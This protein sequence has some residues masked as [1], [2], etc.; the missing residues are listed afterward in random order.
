M[1]NSLWA[2][3]ILLA[4]LTGTTQTFMDGGQ[5][6]NVMA[7]AMF[8]SAKTGV[9]LSIGLIAAL[10]FWLGLFQIGEAAG[11]VSGLARLL[12]PILCRL[13]PDI[14]RGHPVLASIGMNIAMSMLGIDNGALPSGLK[15]MEEL[16]HLKPTNT[17]VGIASRSQQM[18]LVY[19]TCSVTLF[20]ISIMAYRMQAGATHPADVFLPLLLAGYAGLFAGLA[21]MAIVQRLR[22]LDPVLLLSATLLVT[23]LSGIAWSI[24]SLPIASIGPAV[25]LTGN[26][27]LLGT[28]ALFILLA[29]LRKVPVYNTFL[30]GAAKGF[31]MA[32]ELIPYIVG[33][34]V[35]IGLLRASGAFALLQ[36]T[37][38]WACHA[39]GIDSHWALGIPQGIMKTF[40]GAGSRAIMLDTFT[41]HGP[42]SYPGYLS[43]IIQGKSD[44]TFYILAA[45]AGAARLKHLGH[46]VAGSIIAS[47]ISFVVAIIC[48]QVFFN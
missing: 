27:L 32:I 28:V 16:E 18:F 25:T 43:A 22:L 15:A 9:D 36:Q 3:L 8:I 21:Y 35:A 40:S 46:A 4:I 14:P 10:V 24:S 17:Q 45:C 39:T 30:T 42:D 34:L 26:A 29:W 5:T 23:L 11:I 20:P 6:I 19:M 38:T 41:A 1:L 12:S 31:G 37:L 2:G 33:M 7:E 44:T 47:V 48:T 13:M